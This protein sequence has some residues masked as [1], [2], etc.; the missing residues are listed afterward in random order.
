MNDEI[1]GNRD[2]GLLKMI[3]L[4]CMI[5]DHVGARLYPQIMELRV[6]GRIAFPLYIW[7]LVVGACYTRSP[8]RYALRLLLVGLISQPF[9]MLGLNH[10]WNQWNIFFTLLTGYLGVWSIRANRYGSRYWGPVLAL[11][12]PCFVTMDYGWRGV[13]LVMLMYLA[14][15]KRGGVAAV[16]TAFCLYWGTNSYQLRAILGLDLQTAL[17]IYSWEIVK[18]LL[19]LQTLA[20]LALPLILWPRKKRTPFPKA[21]A[22]AAYPGHLIV[23]WLVQLAMGVLTWQ[24]SLRTLIPWM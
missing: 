18:A 24:G 21:L 9:Y 1:A 11:A 15:Q 10:H 16:L 12:V 4:V 5:T 19:R 8:L 13:L 6:I 22:Y 14:R 17:P 3:A 2:T 23:L 7:C 20:I